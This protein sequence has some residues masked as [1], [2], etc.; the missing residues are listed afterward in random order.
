MRG[1]DNE[2]DI[3]GINLKII[4]KFPKFLNIINFLILFLNFINKIF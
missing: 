2:G 4:V 1:T 3:L